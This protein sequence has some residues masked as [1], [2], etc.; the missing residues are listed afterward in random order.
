MRKPRSYNVK[1]AM[2]DIKREIQEQEHRELRERI[3]K[4]KKLTFKGTLHKKVVRNT[5]NSDRKYLSLTEDKINEYNEYLGLM[6]EITLFITYFVSNEDKKK[7]NHE[8]Q[9]EQK[10]IIRLEKMGIRSRNKNNPAK[11]IYRVRYYTQ[12]DKFLEECNV[13]LLKDMKIFE[14]GSEKYKS[15]ERQYKI[16]V[17]DLKR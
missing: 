4:V 15:A 1:D 13:K 6:K 5:N 2:N 7:N 10:N 12:S 17:R 9:I 3:E 8:Y 14:K 16:N 11:N